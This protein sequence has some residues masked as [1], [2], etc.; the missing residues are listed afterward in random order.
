MIDRTRSEIKAANPTKNT[1][2]KSGTNT[3][4]KSMGMTPSLGPML[5][6]R[7]KPQNYTFYTPN[8]PKSS[9]PIVIFL[10]AILKTTLSNKSAPHL[11]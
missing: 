5:E 2:I 3:T 6:T 9:L 8:R 11:D 4:S 1:T 7:N 10:L